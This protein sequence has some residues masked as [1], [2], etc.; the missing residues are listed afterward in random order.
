MLSPPPGL[1]PA[2]P[3]HFQNGEFGPEQRGK[4]TNQFPNNTFLS[5]TQTQQGQN[6]WQHHQFIELRVLE[7]LAESRAASRKGSPC[8]QPRTNWALQCR[9]NSDTTR[10]A[11]PECGADCMVLPCAGLL[12]TFLSKAQSGQAS[13]P[14][15]IRCWGMS[16]WKMSFLP[17][18]ETGCSSQRGLASAVMYSVAGWVAGLD[19]PAPAPGWDLGFLGT[20]KCPN[21][22]KTCV[23]RQDTE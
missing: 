14:K 19:S 13:C 22:H 10:W 4:N 18:P 3:G 9:A 8:P 20:A 17:L 2:L 23:Q 5:T 11:S 7:S 21:D 12:V 1:P 16:T 6:K 15:G